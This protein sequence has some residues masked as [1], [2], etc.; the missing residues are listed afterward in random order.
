[1]MG[2]KTTQSGSVWKL[3]KRGRVLPAEHHG[4]VWKESQLALQYEGA[5]VES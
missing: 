1:M 2:N 4:A 5:G 3:K